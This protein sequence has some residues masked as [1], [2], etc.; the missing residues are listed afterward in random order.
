MNDKK[1]YGRNFKSDAAD[2][3]MNDR[4]P[5]P[6]IM[7]AWRRKFIILC[8]IAF[9]TMP[10]GFMAADARADGPAPQSDAKAIDIIPTP[11]EIKPGSLQMALS[12]NGA[13][14]AVIVI[15]K[16]RDGK[17]AVAADYINKECQRLLANPGFVLPVVSADRIGETDSSRNLIVIGSPQE[18]ACAESCIKEHFELFTGEWAVTAKNPGEQGYVLRFFR[19]RDGRTVAVLAGSDSQGSL[20]AAMSFLFLIKKDGSDLHAQEAAIRDWPDFKIRWMGVA[21]SR[22]AVDFAVRYKINM[23]TSGHLTESTLKDKDAL[24]EVF[25]YA[26][27][28]GVRC[29]LGG[30]HTMGMKAPEGLKCR[31]GKT[32]YQPNFCLGTD[33][34]FNRR[35]DLLRRLVRET[36]PHALYIHGVDIASGGLHG[37]IERSWKTRCDACR[38]KWPSDKMTD[39]KGSAGAMIYLINTMEEAVRR[40]PGGENILFYWVIP[41]YPLLPHDRTQTE[42]IAQYWNLIT[43][44]VSEKSI[45]CAREVCAEHAR[46][47]AESTAKKQPILLYLYDAHHEIHSVLPSVATVARTFFL[48]DRPGAVHFFQPCRGPTRLFT[49]EYAWNCS[50]PGNEMIQTASEFYRRFNAASFELLATKDPYVDGV[51]LPKICR[52]LYGRGAKNMIEFI[53]VNPQLFKFDGALCLL[54][55]YSHPS[56]AF[57]KVTEARNKV[58]IQ[59]MAELRYPPIRARYE[60]AYPYI[61]AAWLEVTS[62]PLVN[63]GTKSEMARWLFYC[64]MG[65]YAAAAL[66]NLSMTWYL[67]LDGRLEDAAAALKEAESAYAAL[68]AYKEDAFSDMDWQNY[69]QTFTNYQRTYLDK[70]HMALSK[71]QVEVRYLGAAAVNLNKA[72]EEVNAN[73]YAAADTRLNAAQRE[74][75]RKPEITD[76]VQQQE[77]ASIH[78]RFI[79]ELEET[80]KWLAWKKDIFKEVA[81]PASRRPLRVAIYDADRDGGVS[82]GKAG[83][84]EAYG[85]LPE[86]EMKPITNLTAA[87]LA[88]CDVVVFSGINRMGAG[89]PGWREEVRKFVDDGG[90]AIFTHH[91]CGG[92]QPALV[93]TFGDSLFPEIVKG[94]KERSEITDL[95]IRAKHPVTEGLAGNSTFKH[96]YYDHMRLVPGPQGIVLADDPDPMAT[97]LIGAKAADGDTAGQPVI[98]AGT[99]G[100]GRVVYFGNVPGFGDGTQN[101]DKAPRYGEYQILLNAIRWVGKRPE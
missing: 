87:T 52:D 100:K 47:L 80:R 55:T 39:L 73:A 90:G 82:M 62:D 50:Q 60:K 37:L 86:F 51:L 70:L 63:D 5:L 34:Y 14:T 75:E 27:T 69:G 96:S 59:E 89:T 40:E 2:L 21:K 97:K 81:S 74:L 66:Q 78:A 30:V 7:R 57:L 68:Q 20:Y 41:P 4:K 46:L 84:M 26:K 38:A 12:R 23:V 18:N 9:I 99:P 53:R 45:L 35:V 8:S 29:V 65:R 93:Y 15:G 72:R 1:S 64:G 31:R 94:I 54:Y 49:S 58:Q 43:R 33:E 11:K 79:K 95:T 67:Y 22:D 17:C 101:I 91:A 36:R 25:D 61:R 6:K 88:G 16:D 19:N 13:P 44:N 32:D 71:A 83:L 76:K 42:E 92:R 48:P 77:Y 10:G 28:R 56:L 24:R 98:V 85:K 3:L